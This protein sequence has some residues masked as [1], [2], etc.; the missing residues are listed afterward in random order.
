MPGRKF[1]F[2]DTA[3][4]QMKGMGGKKKK[5]MWLVADIGWMKIERK[6]IKAAA[7][8]L[9][10]RFKWLTHA[11][12]LRLYIDYGRHKSK[13]K[14]RKDPITQFYVFSHGLSNLGETLE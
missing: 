3:L 1:E 11:S 13:K 2:V 6:R 10:V 7:K 12:D 14:R 4:R 9:G 8:S 5:I